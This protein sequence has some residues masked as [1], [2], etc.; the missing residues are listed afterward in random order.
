MK[1]FRYFYALLFLL[2]LGLQ[3]TLQGQDRGANS[4]AVVPQPSRNPVQQ[5]NAP[6]ANRGDRA[7]APNPRANNPRNTPQNSG[8]NNARNTVQ[9]AGTPPA[10]TPTQRQGNQNNANQSRAANNQRNQNQNRQ[11]GQTLPSGPLVPYFGEPEPAE[12]PILAFG[13]KEP[14]KPVAQPTP[15]PPPVNPPSRSNRQVGP[16]NNGALR[17]NEKRDIG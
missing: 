7:Q 15:T 16:R 13:Q 1:S 6:Q 4:R 3:D 9:R 8:R 14:A 11:N 2:P 10:R 5:G 12:Q 17:Q